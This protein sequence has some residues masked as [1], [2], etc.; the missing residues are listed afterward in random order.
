[1]NNDRELKKLFI[2]TFLLLLVAAAAYA[3]LFLIAGNSIREIGKHITGEKG[4]TG[5]FF[6]VYF[7]DTFIVPATPDPV[8]T[9]SSF[10][11]VLLITVVSVASISGGFTG[12]LIGKYLNHF[13]IVQKLTSHYRKKG[14]KL[15]EKY[16][17]WTVALAGFTPLPYST[18]SWIAGMFKIS[19]CYYL[20]AS[21]TRIPRF[22]LYYA[23][24]RG[25]IK[26]FS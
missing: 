1:M 14:E 16:G 20:I 24:I 4:L 22:I 26:L 7:V 10:S 11:P 21:L 23:A 25:G 5:I 8:F 13:S 3:A 17:P 12:Y 6:Y 18:I 15:I 19:P 9:V 2:K